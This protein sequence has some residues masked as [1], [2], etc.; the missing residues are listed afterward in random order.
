[1][2]VRGVIQL[3]AGWV[4]SRTRGV[5]IAELV[6]RWFPRYAPVPPAGPPQNVVAV[7]SGLE[8]HNLISWEN[9]PGE[10]HPTQT[11]IWASD[12]DISYSL[13][14]TVNLSVLSYQH[15]TGVSGLLQYY[16]LR[17]VNVANN[18]AF[19]TAVSATSKIDGP[20]AAPSSLAA[21]TPARPTGENQIDL[22]WVNG[23]VTASTVAEYREV[24]AGTWLTGPTAA[25]ASTAISITGLAANK[26]WEV[27][28]YHTKNTVNLG[29][30]NTDSTS[31]LVDGPNAGPSALSAATGSLPQYIDVSWTNGDATA[32]TRLFMSTNGVDFNF[33]TQLGVGVTSY[34]HDTGAGGVQRWYYVEHIKN[35]VIHGGTSNTDNA[36]S[37]DLAPIGAPTQ[38]VVAPTAS[39]EFQLNWTNADVYSSIE[40]YLDLNDGGESLLTTLAPG[41]TQYVTGVY[42]DDDKGV[43]RLRHI[44]LGTP[45]TY[46]PSTTSFIPDPIDA[47]PVLDTVVYDAGYNSADI[48]LTP[49]DAQSDT[50]VWYQHDS[51][52]VLFSTLGPGVAAT[53]ITGFPESNKSYPVRLRH[54]KQ[55][56]SGTGYTSVYSNAINA[57]MP[58]MPAPTGV[59]SSHDGVDNANAGQYDLAWTNG[60]ATLHTFLE[61][62]V[63]GV[64]EASVTV[65]P[66]VSAYSNWDLSAH[67]P[68]G[69]TGCQFRFRH[70]RTNGLSVIEYSPAATDSFTHDPGPTANVSDNGSA[71]NDGDITFAWN[72]N[73]AQSALMYIEDPQGS[74]VVSQRLETGSQ[75]VYAVPALGS[76]IY[77]IY[78]KAC[79]NGYVFGSW[80][81]IQ[82]D[83][84]LPVPSGF[85]LTNNG[86]DQF[87]LNWTDPNGWAGV[88]VWEELNDGTE[89]LAQTVTN[90]TET[91]VSST[92]PDNTK[93]QY[94]L[95]STDSKLKSAYSTQLTRYIPDPVD[96][97]PTLTSANY[98]GQY[99]NGNAVWTNGDSGAQTEVWYYYNG[100]ILS[101]TVGAGQTS[102]ALSN[103]PEANKSYD[104]RVRHKKTDLNGT[105]H[106]S[107]YSN[108]IALV[109]PAIPAPTGLSSSHDGALDQ[110]AGQFDVSWSNAD[111]SLK[112]R[113]RFYDSGGLKA[114]RIE[115]AGVSSISNWDLSAYLSAGEAGCSFTVEHEY[116]NPL[117]N[118]QYSA[119]DTDAFTHDSGPGSVASDNGSAWNLGANRIDFAWNLNGAEGV[120]YYITNPVGATVL[121]QTTGAISSLQF[122]PTSGDG[123]YTLFL[124]TCSNGYVFSGGGAWV[125]I[126]IAVVTGP[127]GDPTN[128]VLQDLGYCSG[129]STEVKQLRVTWTNGDVLA[130]TEIYIDKDS[131]GFVL[132]WTAGAGSTQHDFIDENWWMQHYRQYKARVRHV[133]SGAPGGFSNT[134]STVYMNSYCVT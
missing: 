24:G 86:S 23:D 99:K 91:W 129:G 109:T 16:E 32:L 7:T 134:S 76:G 111:A 2:R 80:Q 115:N 43:F 75:Y 56:A 97:A 87:V 94:R 47:P 57:V 26:L 15:D 27:R 38:P 98:T 37:R 48:T 3:G 106:Y 68:A 88:E 12:D 53:K 8:R 127:S 72:E 133:R 5:I 117:S 90:G 13:L 77:T 58:Q 125:S 49:G 92:H 93:G 132:R 25:P 28:L 81:T 19:T 42:A 6:S 61:L 100:W 79:L 70:C 17:H 59:S 40:V 33:L 46:S 10:I 107:S 69:Q 18:S 62:L 14:A 89:V 30:S 52:W 85:S 20:D 44:Y 102:R 116:T 41:T 71:Y 101:A 39:D 34:A 119:A 21:T 128:C 60:D 65:A 112:T 22:T 124:R 50:D 96:A 11:E 73:G 108:I 51:T 84:S 31:T 35:G 122:T 74:V 126:P 83:A 118:Q 64:V 82:V 103:F 113:V 123:T 54:R 55:D 121:S 105:T 104:V 45:S 4:Q 95:R 114:T 110:N 1:M 120:Q 36:T 9:Y 67:L 63:N 66:G 78:L 130:S 29:Y 131:T